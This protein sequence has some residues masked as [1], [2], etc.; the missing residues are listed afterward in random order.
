MILD[1]LFIIIGIA[2]VLW[3]A[4][5]FTDGA[6]ALAR[7]MH[8]PPIVIGLTVVAMGTSAPELC[9]SLASALKGAPGMAVGNIVGSNIFNTLAI[10]GCAA[11]VAPIA[12][13]RGTVKKD[14]PFAVA[15]SVALAVLTLSDG[16]LSRIDAIVLLAGFAGFMTYT[17][18]LARQGHKEEIN[19]EKQESEPEL[20]G[21]W[22]SIGLI[23]L[24]LACL[25]V[26]SDIF[27]TYASDVAHELGVSDAVVGL[28]IVACGTSLPELATSVV[29]ARKGESALAIGNAIG[30]NVFN[31]L[32]IL[33]LTGT[34]CP[35]DLGGITWI[36]M[37]V[38]L[39]SILLLWLFSYTKL[40]VERWEGGT[41]LAVFL[42]YMTWLVI[43]A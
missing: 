31:I 17:L 7:R 39:G 11:L 28:T 32:L 16:R 19:T 14:I 13:G 6:S 3:G 24:G 15:A 35:M 21:V 34:V 26:G 36:D 8:V 43:T 1:F 9:V 37:A 5:K 20:H 12:I 2:L 18:R 4:D 40:R 42:A 33:G 25:I 41:L 22:K 23:L 10:V 27:V 38:L 30:S 29:A